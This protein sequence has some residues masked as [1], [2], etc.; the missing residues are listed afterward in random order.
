MKLSKSNFL[1]NAISWFHILEINKHLDFV[2]TY[3]IPSRLRGCGK[4]K[5]STKVSQENYY[6]QTQIVDDCLNIALICYQ[7]L[8]ILMSFEKWNVKK[9]LK[10]MK[11]AS[12]ICN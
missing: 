7:S 11:E 2:I 3:K 1:R 4:L 9:T 12:S 8:I 5:S 10:Q 6:L